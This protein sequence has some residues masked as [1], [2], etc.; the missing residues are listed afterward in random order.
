MAMGHHH[1]LT[2]QR[3]AVS[4]A[5]LRSLSE[6]VGPSLQ[7]CRTCCMVCGS[8]PQGQAALAHDLPHLS[9]L[10]PVLATLDLALLSVTQSRLD[11]STPK[12]SVSLWGGNASLLFESFF[13]HKSI[14]KIFGGTAVW[15]LEPSWSYDMISAFG[16]LLG[17]QPKL[18]ISAASLLVVPP[19][20]STTT[21]SVRQLQGDPSPCSFVP[22]IFLL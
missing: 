20:Y 13:F 22:S 6:Q 2:L 8:S 19:V 12:G 16:G 7:L 21:N 18:Q 4:L 3:R 10:S 5:S 14:L 11:R 15:G 9:M 1:I 17:K